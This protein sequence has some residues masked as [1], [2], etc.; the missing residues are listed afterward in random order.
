MANLN[1][2]ASQIDTGPT[3][4]LPGPAWGACYLVW[5]VD[6]ADNID[7]GAAGGEDNNIVSLAITVNDPPD[8]VAD[9]TTI[10]LLNG[11][12]YDITDFDCQVVRAGQAVT[13][14]SNFSEKAGN[15]VVDGFDITVYYT[16]DDWTIEPATDTALATNTYIGGLAANGNDTLD[17]DMTFPLD[18]IG[19][20]IGVGSKVDSGND[21]FETDETDAGNVDTGV[22]G[23]VA[24][25][26][27]L[28]PS[29]TAG[30]RDLAV[31][32]T[33]RNSGSNIIPGAKFMVETSVNCIGDLPAGAFRVGIYASTDATVT[34]SDALIGSASVT[35][36][37][38]MNPT[39][40]DVTCTAPMA[41]DDYYLGAI[42]DD[43]NAVTEINENNNTYVMDWQLTVVTE[44]PSV[45]LT[46]EGGDGPGLP[47]GIALNAPFT[48]AA[49]FQ[50]EGNSGTGAFDLKFYVSSDTTITTSD[51][52][53]A[54]V[55]FPSGVAAG[56]RYNG[57]PSLTFVTCTL[58]AAQAAAAGITVPGPVSVGYIVDADGV[59]AETDETDNANT[60]QEDISLLAAGEGL[61]DLA[62]ILYMDM[63]SGSDLVAPVPPSCYVSTDTATIKVPMI[64]GANFGS[65]AAPVV[66]IRF[67]LADSTVTPVVPANDINLG[68]YSLAVL[69]AGEYR[70]LFDTASLNVASVTANQYYMYAIID[71]LDAVIESDETNNDSATLTMGGGAVVLGSF[72][73]VIFYDPP[74]KPELQGL[75]NLSTDSGWLQQSFDFQVQTINTA[76]DM[77][78]D[79]S[80]A[81][82]FLSNDQS[83]TLDPLDKL[84][85]INDVSLLQ[86]G[87]NNSMN[88]ELGTPMEGELTE[89]ADYSLKFVVDLL[90]EIGEV[91]EGN[92]VAV[93][94]FDCLIAEGLNA[95]PIAGGWSVAGA[96]EVWDD[97]G[98]GS[99]YVDA[100]DTGLP[101]DTT[102]VSET[103]DCTGY[104]QVILSFDYIC[105]FTGNEDLW[106]QV[107][108]GGGA[109]QVARLQWSSTGSAV[110]DI[111]G[112][113]ADEASVTI[114]WRFIANE[115]AT[116]ECTIDNISVLAH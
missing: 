25:V 2:G 76:L 57:G 73:P 8:L 6:S 27:V 18:L 1:P 52:L 111:S 31:M 79:N 114:Q 80:L 15:D 40:V 98:V 22:P 62:V 105:N 102:L 83:P 64:L 12:L 116:G 49:A 45:N 93:W 44:S 3:I 28:N 101:T 36:Q 55:P 9:G 41:E 75:A 82:L 21:V 94:A 68:D 67:Y 59:V 61:S 19:T 91:Q 77:K 84:I 113:A 32:R 74:A 54:T 86:P 4:A 63:G 30:Q 16:N 90:G 26:L 92:N 38:Y 112:Y 58:T 23:E 33:D 81:A 14:T 96:G 88:A 47:Y 35:V 65:A 78:A 85:W 66:P 104:T 20:I 53:V 50:C 99:A 46:A 56:Y 48:I 5:V 100:G 34:T 106:I 17:I 95:W 29:I 89:G 39:D 97:S 11:A 103:I 107:D 7:E 42:A 108:N 87:M 10:G 37:S 110:L 69:G 51:V 70:M 60:D 115:A 71:P 109:Q 24:L 13:A 72:V 43:L